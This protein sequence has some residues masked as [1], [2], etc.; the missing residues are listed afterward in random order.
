MEDESIIHE[1]AMFFARGHSNAMTASMPTIHGFARFRH[2][3]EALS[4]AVE[5]RDRARQHLEKML[6]KQ[7]IR[8]AI[9]EPHNGHRLA[10]L[11]SD[12]A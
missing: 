5:A 7:R 8:E 12:R 11:R 2:S 6:E 4:Y 9:M 1:M 3:M 10:G